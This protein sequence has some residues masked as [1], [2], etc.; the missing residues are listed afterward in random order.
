MPVVA[1]VDGA[2]RMRPGRVLAQERQQAVAIAP[3]HV[4]A[5]PL[6][7]ERQMREQPARAVADRIGIALDGP[8][9]LRAALIDRDRRDAVGDRRH[10]LHRGRAGADHGD[11]LAVEL[12]VVRPQRRMQDRA[13]EVFLALE[14][15]AGGIVELADGR[16]QRGGFKGFFAALR[17]QRRDPAPLAFVPARR[18]QLGID[19][20]MLA[21]AVFL[22]DLLQ[23]AEHLLALA[24]IAA[25]MH[26]PSPNE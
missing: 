25:S 24:E 13:L 14:A 12:D 5:V 11:M 8:R 17:L 18:C 10:Q 3:E 1:L 16:D 22:G 4:E 7:I 20:Q 21:D 2:L 9:P 15:G 26:C 6:H 23:I 19:A